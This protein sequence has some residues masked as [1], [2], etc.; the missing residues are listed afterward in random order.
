MWL[1][2]CP[3]SIENILL[4]IVVIGSHHSGRKHST[5]DNSVF[6]G[7]E[8]NNLTIITMTN[9]WFHYGMGV[10]A[11]VADGALTGGIGLGVIGAAVGSGLGGVG[12]GATMKYL[13]PVK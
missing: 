10:L 5:K 4:L 11:G 8:R 6:N 2:M 12:G 7:I 9:S 3:L 13:S 1:P